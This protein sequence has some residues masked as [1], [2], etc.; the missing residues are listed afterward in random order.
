MANTEM[1]PETIRQLAAKAPVYTFGSEALANLHRANRYLDGR[2]SDLAHE[3]YVVAHPG[4]NGSEAFRTLNIIIGGKWVPYSY[5]I[6]VEE[7]IIA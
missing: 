7:A 3:V 2:Y 5:D 6:P 4:V 1:S